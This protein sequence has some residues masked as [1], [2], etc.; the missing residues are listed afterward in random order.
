MGFINITLYLVLVCY[1]FCQSPWDGMNIHC[2]MEKVSVIV[3]EDGCKNMNPVD[4]HY[5]RG[6]CPSATTYYHK[7]PYYKSIC[8]CCKA[9]AE[10]V[11]IISLD[12]PPNELNGEKVTKFAYR[13]TVAECKCHSCDATRKK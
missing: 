10:T 4:L 8:Q 2:N 9:T 11:K 12:C 5:C 6:N 7:Y 3:E 13:N 1:S